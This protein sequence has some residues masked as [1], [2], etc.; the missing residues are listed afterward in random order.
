MQE[1]PKDVI[2]VDVIIPCYHCSDTISRA[3]ESVLHQTVSPS[4]IIIVNDCGDDATSLV[5]EGIAEK[6]KHIVKVLHMPVNQGAASARNSGWAKTENT[7]IAFLDADDSWHPEK[8]NLQYT[9]MRNNPD[10][11]LS[12]HQCHYKTD[13]KVE[14][15]HELLFRV[16]SIKKISLLFK[17]PFSTPTVMVKRNINYRFKNGKR[18]AEDI[19]LW[20]QIAFSG[21]KV[22]RMEIPLAYVH[23]P[24]YG[25][26]GLSSD[27]WKME[28]EELLNYFALF[29]GEKIGVS[30]LSV[31]ALFSF[32][33]YIKRLL[34]IFLKNIYGKV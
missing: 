2:P 13:I 1:M 12:G 6:Y 29:K 9:Y 33:K 26:S 10:I 14:S 8:L 31:A 27:L 23:K 19:M 7:Y 21:A 25:H 28:K 24:L 22:V 34:I 17:N 11:I 30:L 4:N 5:L 18:Y 32:I 3:V 15:R 16:T 20:L